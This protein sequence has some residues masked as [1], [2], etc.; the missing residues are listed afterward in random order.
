[1]KKQLPTRKISTTRSQKSVRNSGAWILSDDKLFLTESVETL[2]DQR[3]IVLIPS[4]D[5]AQ[6]AALLS[7]HP[8]Q[9]YSKKQI[10]Y[11]YQNEAIIMQVESVLPESIK[12]KTTFVLTLKPSP[13]AQGNNMIEVNFNGYSADEIA[14]LRAHF[15]L[16]NELLLLIRT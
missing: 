3:V 8:E 10:H 14:E 2:I 7:L 16:L 15:L 11:A 13:Q 12:G 9:H 5:S 6:E 1:V 4:V